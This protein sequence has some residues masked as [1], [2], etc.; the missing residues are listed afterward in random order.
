MAGLKVAIAEID[1]FSAAV[2]R[3]A[4]GGSA[5]DSSI[6]SLL[7]AGKRKAA[8]L[9][10]LSAREREVLSLMAEG[11]SSGAIA[12]RLVVTPRAIEKHVTEIFEK[13]HLGAAV[14]DHRRVLAVPTFLRASD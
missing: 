1:D 8:P 4:Q 5:L 12:E 7:V 3:V 6:L 14:E 2:S 11:R 13:L 10:V 9:E